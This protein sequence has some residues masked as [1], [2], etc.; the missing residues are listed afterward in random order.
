[1]LS[2]EGVLNR[3]LSIVL[4][5]VSSATVGLRSPEVAFNVRKYA[6]PVIV[7]KNVVA[8]ITGA[9][10]GIIVGFIPLLEQDVIT[11]IT[12]VGLSEILILFGLGVGIGALNEAIAKIWE[13]AKNEDESGSK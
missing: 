3:Y 6:T 13:T 5:V 7:E 4:S 9:A 1:L 10:F 2:V 12:E 11:G 8:G